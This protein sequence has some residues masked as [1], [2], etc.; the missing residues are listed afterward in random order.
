M[1]RLVRAATAAAR[2]FGDPDNAPMRAQALRAI[3]DAMDA[4]ADDLVPIAREETALADARLT[5]ELART[6]YQLR[7][8]AEVIDEGSA[9]EATIDSADPDWAL[10]PKPDLR[11]VLIGIGPVAMYS[12]SNFPF[13]FSVAGGDTAAALAAGCPVIVKGHPGHPLL[14]QAVATIV[15]DQL[16]AVGRTCGHLRARARAGGGQAARSPSRA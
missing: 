12:A 2:E 13:A 3:A 9:F 1:S 6:T 4:A 11:R 15:T 10:G 14:S 7:R 16:D 5:S 8:F